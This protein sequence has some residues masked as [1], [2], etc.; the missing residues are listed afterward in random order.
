MMLAGLKYMVQN[1]LIAIGHQVNHAHALCV[2]HT[3]TIDQNRKDLIE[4]KYYYQMKIKTLDENIEKLRES[5]RDYKSAVNL[6]RMHLDIS[7]IELKY[8]LDRIKKTL[9]NAYG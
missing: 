5:Q 2:V 3:N 8:K 9:N 4:T 1:G 7:D 6:L